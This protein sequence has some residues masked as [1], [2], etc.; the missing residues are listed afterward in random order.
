[1]LGS[2]LP[3]VPMASL[4][5]ASCTRFGRWRP[6]M[7]PSHRSS[8]HPHRAQGCPQDLDE[9]HMFLFYAAMVS[10]VLAGWRAEPPATYVVRCARLRGCG[11]VRCQPLSPLLARLGIK[12][13]NY[14][15]LDVEG[16]ELE[17]LEVCEN[18]GLTGHPARALHHVPPPAG[19]CLLLKH[20]SEAVCC[21]ACA[22]LLGV[23]LDGG[24]VRRHLRGD[25]RDEP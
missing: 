5:G 4:S 20:A 15:V 9:G 25:P 6:S 12:H 23:R 17:I 11:Q 13:I 3:R 2:T 18:A 1:L 24:H 8:C 7:R 14:W 22:L 10:C 16:A 21:V 19:T